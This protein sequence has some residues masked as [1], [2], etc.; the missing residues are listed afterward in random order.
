MQL[1]RFHM[2]H[3]AC[4]IF[5]TAAIG[6]AQSLPADPA[7]EVASI[8]PNPDCGGPGRGSGG[9]ASPGRMTLECAQ[10]RD[11]ILTAYG[12]YA[13]GSSPNP[14]SFRMQVLGGPGWIDSDR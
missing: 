3:I 8:K 13:N 12:I 1:Q 9:M 7:F 4:L 10:L 2:A 14:G 5:V 11:L 6:R